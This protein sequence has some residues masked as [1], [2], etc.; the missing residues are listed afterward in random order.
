MAF[1]DFV[2]RVFGKTPVFVYRIEVPGE[3]FHLTSWPFDGAAFGWTASAD[4]PDASYPAGVFFDFAGINR[5]EIIETS[6]S[7]RA[8]VW[9]SLPTAHPA[10]AAARLS[11]ELEEEITVTIWLTYLGDPD[12]EYITRFRGRVTAIEPGKILSRLICADDMTE[13]DRASSAQVASVLCRH[14]HYFTEA[15]G[16]G[17]TL[18]LVDWQQAATVTAMTGRVVTV[19]LAALQPD[20]TYYLGIFEYDGREYLI[21]D[22]VGNQLT[23]DRT[24]PGLA[25]AVG[26]G[27]V[28]VLIAPGCDQRIETCLGRF[29]NVLNYGG[30]PGMIRG[31]TPFDGRSIA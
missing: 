6:A 25:T 31:E 5:G 11:D 17:C 3:T 23:L 1:A 27:A 2:A 30:L 28:A 24:P 22:H 21:A 19:A 18:D 16:T 29:D 10:M 26:V 15:D 14:T 9:V 8:E 12:E 4:R 7:T 13:M 20:G